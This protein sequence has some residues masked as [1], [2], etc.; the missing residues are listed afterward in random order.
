ML[1]WHLKVPVIPSTVKLV[2]PT[3][4]KV[5]TLLG[6][7]PQASLNEAWNELLTP[8]SLAGLHQKGLTPLIYQELYRQGREKSCNRTTMRQLQHDFA[9]SLQ[10]AARQA[11]EAHKVMAALNEAQVEFIVLKG[12]DLRLRVYDDPAQKPMGDLD[13]LVDQAQLPQVRQALSQLDYHIPP[14][15][16]PCP[17]FRERFHYELMFIPPPGGI[18]PI[19]VHWMLRE[20]AHFYA[21]PSA[22]LRSQ[23]VAWNYAGMQ[24]KLLAP[25]HLLIH[26]CLHAMGHLYPGNYLNDKQV[27][28]IAMVLTR[29]AIDWSKFLDE[30]VRFK[31][32]APVYRVL[33]EMGHLI[34][35]AVLEELSNYRPGPLE[36][37]V[38]MSRLKNLARFLL[39]MRNYPLRECLCFVGAYL[40]PDR[41]YL[42]ALGQ[43]GRT[44]YFRHL[45]R[46]I[47]P[48]PED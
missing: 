1:L 15:C 29:L 46:N 14:V 3:A 41:G 33:R 24:I 20:M 10:D 35:A 32:S 5:L 38:L 4:L 18:L 43:S 44:G 31:C 48:S 2:S 39:V 16:Y 8:A 7:L 22:P 19:D 13:L 40:W 26:L 37:L 30:A 6:D 42:E 17:R 28:D 11:R 12:M 34:P 47:F 23:A 36:R 21:L 27:V 25:E 45:C 9:L